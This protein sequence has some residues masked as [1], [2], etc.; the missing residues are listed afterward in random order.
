MGVGNGLYPDF[1]LRVEVMRRDQQ[2]QGPPAQDLA[3]LKAESEIRASSG[4]LGASEED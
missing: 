2:T 3:M 4:Q 1:A